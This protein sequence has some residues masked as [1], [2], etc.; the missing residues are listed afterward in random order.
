MIVPIDARTVR[1]V[2][3]EDTEDI[4]MFPLESSERYTRPEVR[5]GEENGVEAM[6]PGTM[7][8]VY[9]AVYEAVVPR[10]GESLRAR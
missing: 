6:V 9:E 1:G 2:L 4:L 3:A 5:Y 7:A 8:L 10:G